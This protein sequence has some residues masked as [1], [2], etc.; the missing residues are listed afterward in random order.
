MAIERK[1]TQRLLIRELFEHTKRPLSV[2]E[3]LETAS[4]TLPKLGV[5]TVYRSINQLVEEN[6]LKP[7]E[8]PGETKRYER[9]DIGHHHH[10][11]CRDCGRI[12]DVK[13]CPKN[14]SQM[15]PVGFRLQSHEVILYGLCQSCDR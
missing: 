8:L 2:A 7:V 10:F 6:W 15:L 13:G 12:F 4:Q 3:V 14:L 5:A 1:T 11:H 9:S